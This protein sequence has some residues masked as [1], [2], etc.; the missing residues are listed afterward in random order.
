[1]GFALLF[2]T[3]AH[4]AADPPAQGS[5]RVAHGDGASRR[6]DLVAAVVRLPVDRRRGHRDGGALARHGKAAPLLEGEPLP[7]TRRDHRIDRHVRHIG[8]VRAAEKHAR[9][10]GLDDRHR[11]RRRVDEAPEIAGLQP[12]H[13]L[14]AC[15]RKRAGCKQEPKPAHSVILMRM[16][17]LV[18]VT[19]LAALAPVAA[20]AQFYDLDG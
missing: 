9:W 4:V 19:V 15:E 14:A 10:A 6:G 16:R 2:E 13:I 1:M 18:P 3:L 11:W 5:E 12:L 8:H 20:V 17:W 7:E